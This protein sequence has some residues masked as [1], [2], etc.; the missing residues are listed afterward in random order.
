[1]CQVQ[2]FENSPILYIM[3]NMARTAGCSCIGV[4]SNVELALLLMFSSIEVKKLP[5]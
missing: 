2:K 3:C 5:P 1:M 4:F